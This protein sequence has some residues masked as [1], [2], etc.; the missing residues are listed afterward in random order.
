MI[1]FL[2]HIDKGL[3]THLSNIAEVF[4]NFFEKMKQLE[5]ISI[6]NS[7]INKVLNETLDFCF[8][9]E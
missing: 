7:T 1:I 8:S 6:S 3:D 5:E 9:F 4:I 2:E